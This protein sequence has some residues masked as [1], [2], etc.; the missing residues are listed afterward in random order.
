MGQT[1]GSGSGLTP[2]GGHLRTGHPP[3]QFLPPGQALRGHV[4]EGDKSP[5]QGTVSTSVGNESQSSSLARLEPE[6]VFALTAERFRIARVRPA[7]LPASASGPRHPESAA[8]P[9]EIP[10]RQSGQEIS[11]PHTEWQSWYGSDAELG[12][13]VSA[14]VYRG[15]SAAG[16]P[17]ACCRA[18]LSGLPGVLDNPQASGIVGCD[19]VSLGGRVVALK[20]FRRAGQQAFSLEVAA[21]KM[22]GVHPNVVRLLEC[23]PAQKAR[24]LEAVLVYEFC[25]G[26]T[27]SSVV[28]A[29]EDERRLLQVLLV[30]RI[31]RQLLRALAHVA[32]CGVEHQDVKPENIFL[33]RVSLPT[34][35]AQVK[36]GD[37]GWATIGPWRETR[38]LPRS[39]IGSLWYAPPELNPL[40]AAASSL[41][42]A[43]GSAS[44]H[45]VTAAGDEQPVTRQPRLGPGASSQARGRAGVAAIAAGSAVS[46]ATTAGPGQCQGVSP[47]AHP[48]TAS[49]ELAAPA[50]AAAALGEPQVPLDRW[51]QPIGSSDM[52][53]T[54]VLL[55]SLL[56]GRNPFHQAVAS[57]SQNGGSQKSLEVHVVSLVCRGQFDTECRE[58][59]SMPKDAR[60]LVA[61]MMTVAPSARPSAS[62][63]L[64]N[65]WLTRTLARGSAQM[66]SATDR[67]P[68][69]F[70]LSLAGE[71]WAQLDGFQRLGWLAVARAVGEPE[72]A[73]EV[74]EEVAGMEA[75]EFP[76]RVP[77]QEAYLF[78]LAAVLAASPT[79]QWLRCPA[80]WPEILRLAFGYLDVDC[81]GILTEQDLTVHLTED[82]C[83][84]LAQAGREWI[85]RWGV[86]GVMTASGDAVKAISMRGVFGILPVEACMDA[87]LSDSREPISATP[88]NRQSSN[89]ASS[90][91]G[92]PD[93]P[94]RA[95]L[96]PAELQS[97]LLAT[98]GSSSLD[99]AR[100]WCN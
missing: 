60:V 52:W 45:V 22:V 32:D 49:P 100:G 55:Y 92:H 73:D 35:E 33:H 20:R 31:T 27:L 41:G 10:G 29:A 17:L 96:R 16:A 83:A 37:F 62:D 54:G 8:L 38:D 51:S 81:D 74:L 69:D 97:A 99:A 23:F 89:S 15:G 90:V 34:H 59:R 50:E 40:P 3:H 19:K 88:S 82:H 14:T 36:L 68:D 76:A 5:S 93:W 71:R 84:D 21:I 44:V 1:C 53:S 87:S 24:G 79:G 63:V 43:A 64:M 42:P 94:A 95:G 57:A 80:A 6:Q 12:Q 65:A 86:P 18:H 78:K 67:K 11:V 91:C 46:A 9:V 72:L 70:V 26:L 77:P 4:T 56:V 58:W 75:V 2:G 85:A 98:T 13:G 47:C 61:S 25:E 30:A 48:T 28:K 66:S 7:Q 39:G